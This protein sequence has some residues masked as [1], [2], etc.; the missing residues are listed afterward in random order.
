M[1]VFIIINKQQ[2]NGEWLNG[3]EFILIQ[4]YI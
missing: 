1:R 3:V 2:G 4:V